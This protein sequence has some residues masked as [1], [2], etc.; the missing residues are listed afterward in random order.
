MERIQRSPVENY[1]A[2][3]SFTACYYMYWVDSSDGN[4]RYLVVH[5]QEWT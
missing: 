3:S 1:S 2:L 5:K 4:Y